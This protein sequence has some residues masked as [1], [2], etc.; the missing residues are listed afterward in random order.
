[1]ARRV[2]CGL[3]P[4]KP[5][6]TRFAYRAPF[7]V[8]ASLSK[9]RTMKTQS[10]IITAICLTMALVLGAAAYAEAAYAAPPNVPSSQG[11]YTAITVSEA[12]TKAQT[13]PV[14]DNPMLNGSALR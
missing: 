3:E 9:K 8:N 2:C 14:A 4:T 13:M 12:I 11:D 6:H 10:T 1:M 7:P 5:R